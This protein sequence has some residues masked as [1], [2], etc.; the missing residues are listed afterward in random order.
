MASSS[1]DGVESRLGALGALMLTS[2]VFAV[3]HLQYS[4]QGMAVVFG[5]GLLFGV[6]RWRSGSTVLTILMHAVWNLTV[7]TAVMLSA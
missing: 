7:G 4:V 1:A 5:L 6:M 3:I 2:L